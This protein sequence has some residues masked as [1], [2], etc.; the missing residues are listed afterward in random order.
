MEKLPSMTE[1]RSFRAL[2]YDTRRVEL[3]R[4]IVPPY[5]VIAPDEREGYRLLKSQRVY[6]RELDRPR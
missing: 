1:V 2:R 6:Q 5:D 4:V 3:S